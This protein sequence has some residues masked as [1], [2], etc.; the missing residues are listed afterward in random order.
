MEFKM[1]VSLDP[2]LGC[3]QAHRWRKTSDGWKGVLDNSIVI[4]TQT[5]DGFRCEG[6][7]SRSK[8]LEYFRHSDDLAAIYDDMSASDSYLASIA[9]ACPGLRLLKQ[10]PW[11]C[12]A[13]YILAVN[14]NVKR[15]S[16][17]VESVCDEFGRDL[18]DFRTFPTP[19]EIL[20]GA[21]KITVCKLGY[22][23]KRFIDFARAVENGDIDLDAIGEMDYENCREALKKIHG[24]GDK[25]ADC[26]SL[27]AFDHMESFPVDARIKAVL[28]DVY[29]IEGNYAELANFG[30]KNFGNYPGY[31]QELLYHARAISLEQAQFGGSRPVSTL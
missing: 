6:N 8:V 29:G 28:R 9:K 27:F 16:S 19:G 11:E 12:T 10:D 17:M 14:A 15:I 1:D 13:T 21:D 26:V 5:A 18:G 31:A 30:R 22:R 25:V 3:G 2:T 20:D 24:I 7:V 23:E 4:L